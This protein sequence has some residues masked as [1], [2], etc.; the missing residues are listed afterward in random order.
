MKKV[1]FFITIMVMCACPMQAQFSTAYVTGGILAMSGN[2]AP[3]F[4]AG[5]SLSFSDYVD[6]GVQFEYNSVKYEHEGE[7]HSF[8]GHFDEFLY[9]GTLDIWF[10]NI[11]DIRLGAYTALGYASLRSR[12]RYYD[13]Y[14]DYYYSGFAG[15]LGLR[16]QIPLCDNL[17]LLLAAGGQLIPEYNGW[18]FDSSKFGV[19]AQIGLAAQF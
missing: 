3:Q 2:A 8:S 10:L 16:G 18:G 5:Y 13:Y 14:D 17:C 12:G 6:I 4:S 19:F 1:L 9:Y 7:H 15:K 11:E